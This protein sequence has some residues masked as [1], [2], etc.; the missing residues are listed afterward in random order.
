MSKK[1]F[2][3]GINLG[4]DLRD[5]SINVKEPIKQ[6]FSSLTKA[7][8]S[9]SSGIRDLDKRMCTK[10]EATILAAT[11][12][13]ECKKYASNMMRII[14]TKVSIDDL[15]LVDNKGID[16]INQLKDLINVVD[17]QNLAIVDLTNRVNLINREVDVLKNPNLDKIFAYVDRKI[18]NVNNDIDRKLSIKADKIEIETAV[19]ARLE[20]MLRS[21]HSQVKDIQREVL[22]SAT[23]DEVKIL[24]TEMA[25]NNDLQSLS[26]I[27]IT[28]RD[29]QELL[30]THV[31]KS[32][33]LQDQNQNQSISQKQTQD[34]NNSSQQ[35][36]NKVV[37]PPQFDRHQIV[38]IVEDVLSINLIPLKHRLENLE[39]LPKDLDIIKDKI[40]GEKKTI[41]TKEDLG[42][43]S[44]S[45]HQEVNHCL[46]VSTY[47]ILLIIY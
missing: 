1:G 33:Q 16:T 25:T 37:I 11:K 13:E 44:Q 30:S 17:S 14:D 35:N 38:E 12:V 32:I 31:E 34:F 41:N 21:V 45:L 28:R 47:L 43:I 7:I 2:L 9:Q 22:K 15:L 27:T 29:L 3:G 8:R 40:K 42:N 24:S 6:L 10:D 26:S 20:D 18:T 39:I 46:S 36:I 23:K 5:D 4:D 19:P